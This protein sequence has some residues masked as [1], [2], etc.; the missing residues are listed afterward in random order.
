MDKI[1]IAVVGCGSIGLR[2]LRILLKDEEV[3]PAALDV[4]PKGLEEAAALSP[5]IAILHSQEELA[6]WGP[7]IVI[8]ATPNA[9][10][11]QNT[12]D[13]FAMGAHVLCEK[14]ISESV[15]DAEAMVAAAQA[16]GKVL[17]VGQSERYRVA[18]DKLIK[19]ANG[20]QL[21]NLIGGR[22]MVGTYNT[23]LCA[24]DPRHRGETFGAI[25]IDYVHELDILN[26][27][28]GVAEE[29][30]CFGNRLGQKERQ[31]NP[32]LAAGVVRY[33]RGEVVSIHFDYVQH[34]Q[35]RLLEI[36]G[37]K[38]VMAYD[39][40]TDTLTTWQCDKADGVSETFGNDRDVQFFQEHRDI[41]DAVRGGTP[42][43][44]PGA[45]AVDVMRTAEKMLASLGKNYSGT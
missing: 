17:A 3:A 10:H 9:F 40:Q 13:A 32:S 29:V 39:F 4:T 2:H 36:Y 18:I 19:A 27:I 38:G 14:P 6:A 35:R 1:R 7:E 12:L 20:G 34:P 37:D 26:A 41:I 21:G 11:K 45:Q 28:F 8:V 43:R 22:A 44:I 42:P 15:A 5:A 30:V 25:V 24:K 31:A 16:A 33:G 23:L